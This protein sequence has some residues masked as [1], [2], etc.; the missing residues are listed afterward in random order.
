MK[1]P[2]KIAL[3]GAGGIGCHLAPILAR[4]A[5][6]VI[7]DADSY[8]P[9][10]VTRQF[11]ALK[12]AGNKAQILSELVGEHTLNKVGFI[13]GYLK[14]ITIT[15]HPQW[16]GVD[17]II[18]G[19]DNNAS[20]EIICEVAE[21]LELPAILAGNE[22]EHGEAHLIAHDTPILARLNRRNLQPPKAASAS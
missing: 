19:V 3:I 12:H 15:N 6:L 20:R 11:P 22:H 1:H 17:F 2:T 8:E 10:N 21:M 13:D 4:M 7:V 16:A 5:D 18:A 9:K 14:D